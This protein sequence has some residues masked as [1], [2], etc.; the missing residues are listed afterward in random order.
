MQRMIGNRAVGAMLTQ[1]RPAAVVQRA[2]PPHDKPDPAAPYVAHPAVLADCVSLLTRLYTT[3][4]PATLAVLRQWKTLAIGAVFD[5]DD[6]DVT[7]YHWTSSGNW[8][9]PAVAAVLAGLGVRRWDADSARQPRGAQGAPGDAEQRLMSGDHILKAV[10]VS[11]PPCPDCAAALAD[12]GH[13]YGR[14]LLSVATPPAEREHQARAQAASAIRAAADRVSRQ[15]ELYEGEHKVQAALINEPSFTGFAGYW[16]NRLFNRDIP[17]PTI[18]IN[19]YGSLLA[20]E[21]ALARGDIR[22]ATANLIRARRHLLVALKTYTTWKD[23][24]EAAGTKAEAAIAAVAIASVVA[25]VAGPLVIEWLG[26]LLGEGAAE[27]SAEEQVAARIAETIERSDAAFLTAEEQITEA[28]IQAEAL[29]EANEFYA[30]L[31]H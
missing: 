23:G 26:E 18:W 1:A 13:E 19:A 20:V 2:D 30:T 16:T 27:A 15:L 10:A 9:D 28:E 7:V 17:P 5:P 14:V 22:A 4:S 6:P 29:E 21:S 11:R 25:F 8:N 31:G 24:I 3:L 12:Y